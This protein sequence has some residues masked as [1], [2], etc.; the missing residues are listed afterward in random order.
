VNSGS[1]QAAQPIAN[2]GANSQ[3]APSANTGA[4][5]GA[6]TGATSTTGT[7][8][9]QGAAARKREAL[10]NSQPKLTNDDQEEEVDLEEGD[11]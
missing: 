7:S 2:S 9:V 3:L 5:T 8:A 10:R 4:S 6:S 1:A 11:F